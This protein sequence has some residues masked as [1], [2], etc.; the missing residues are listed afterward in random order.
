[1]EMIFHGGPALGMREEVS[2]SQ[3]HLSL[4]EGD[5]L[6]LY[7]DGLLDGAG[8]QE[9]LTRDRLVEA[10]SNHELAG[11]RLPH[12]LLDMSSY[13]ASGGKQEDDITMLLLSMG[14]A[15]ST[16]DNG[17]P[18]TTMTAQPPS[19]QSESEVLIGSTDE[20]T[21]ICIRGRGV[22]SSC[23]RFHDVCLAELRAHHP[24]TLDFSGCKYLDSTFLGTIQEVIDEAAEESVKRF[25][26]VGDK[27][28]GQL[29]VDVLGKY[30]AKLARGGRDLAPRRVARRP[31]G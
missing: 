31:F 17:E 1:M 12:M 24:L 13:R 21:G 11:P 6:L 29:A 3:R 14:E 25:A 4:A 26:L 27:I 30:P 15:A 9:P 19:A 20:Y 7:T 10:M 5:R 8:Q 23:P 22:W 18:A 2:F 16:L 28:G